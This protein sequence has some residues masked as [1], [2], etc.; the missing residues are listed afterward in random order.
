MGNSNNKEININ[1][2]DKDGNTK[3]MRRLLKYASSHYYASSRNPA[4]CKKIIDI[5]E[6]KHSDLNIQNNNGDTALIIASKWSLHGHVELLIKNGANVNIQNKNGD[7]A[8]NVVFQKKNWFRK[9]SSVHCIIRCLV[10]A[11]VDINKQNEEGN[12]ILMDI[13]CNGDYYYKT[14]LFLIKEGADID[15]ENNDGETALT[16]AKNNRQWEAVMLLLLEKKE[17]NEELFGSVVQIK[18]KKEEER[19]RR[20][21][22]SDKRRDLSGSWF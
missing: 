9:K 6:N 12:T 8:L 2:Q 5:V 1:A 18:K 7:T 14:I 22:S 17:A 4:T 16:L 3:L 19:R 10:Q 15:I 20:A 21:Q 13:A 11:N